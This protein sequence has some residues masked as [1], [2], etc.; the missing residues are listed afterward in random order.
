[1]P[2]TPG[3]VGHSLVMVASA[4]LF[5]EIVFRGFLIAYVAHFTGATTPGLVAAVMLPAAVFGLGH[6]YQGWHAVLKIVLL[7]GVFGWI[8][9]VTG[10]LWIPIALHFLVD[11]IGVCLGPRL[12][13]D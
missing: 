1:M 11:L 8:L 12:L 7:A 10:S 13:R 3:E 9:V 4:A 2:A 5:E 6:L